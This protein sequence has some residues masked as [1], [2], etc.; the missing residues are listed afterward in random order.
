MVVANFFLTL[1]AQDKYILPNAYSF[2]LYCSWWKK[3]TQIKS[4]GS[5]HLGLEVFDYVSFR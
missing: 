5:Q 2:I 3:K 1:V 4:I